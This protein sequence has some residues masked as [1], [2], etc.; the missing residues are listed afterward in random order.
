MCSGGGVQQQVVAVRKAPPQ[1]WEI[2]SFHPYV[3]NVTSILAVSGVFIFFIFFRSLVVMIFQP[4][5]SLEKRISMAQTNTKNIHNCRVMPTVNGVKRSPTSTNFTI[6]IYIYKYPIFQT[7][8]FFRFVSV[9]ARFNLKLKITVVFS[10]SLQKEA[11]Y[12]T[13][14]WVHMFFRWIHYESHLIVVVERQFVF[15]DAAQSNGISS[16]QFLSDLA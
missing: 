15:Q 6:Y 10:H 1:D 7:A 5:L 16:S 14:T 11:K 8:L 4:W 2:K 12:K 9:L 13:A 3:A